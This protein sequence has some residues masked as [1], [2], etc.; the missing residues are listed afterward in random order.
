MTPETP[1]LDSKSELVDAFREAFASTRG[2]YGFTVLYALLALVVYFGGQ[3]VYELA[4][5]GAPA[6]T[7][8]TSV[9]Q[10]LAGLAVLVLT[11]HALARWQ[12][13]KQ[14]YRALAKVEPRVPS[15]LRA[16]FFAQVHRMGNGG[17]SRSEG[18]RSE[19][20]LESSTLFVGQFLT[21]I[22][23]F[24]SLPAIVL[25]LSYPGYQEL[26]MFSLLVA[27]VAVQFAMAPRLYAAESSAEM[28]LYQKAP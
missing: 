12:A 6:A 24:V 11:L 5:I 22:F 23:L 4:S 1:A 20:N 18:F 25:A 28:G 14:V 19:W 16:W 17:S 26:D 21:S 10:L 7:I 27:I 15:A 2:S 13:Y 9:L 3:R 8:V